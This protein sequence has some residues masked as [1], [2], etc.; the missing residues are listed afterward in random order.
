MKILSS[1]ASEF[2]GIWVEK[3]ESKLVTSSQDSGIQYVNPLPT[4]TFLEPQK[5]PPD[6]RS[7]G[8]ST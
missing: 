6:V 3:R 7:P 8:Q 4:G 2:R 5:N 1:V